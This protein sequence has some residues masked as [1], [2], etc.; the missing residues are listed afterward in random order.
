MN[1]QEIAL[2]ISKA[3]SVAPIVAIRQGDRNATTLK[4]AVFD[5]GAAF[6][7]SDY[8]VLL[9]AKLP[10]GA[11]Y[12]SAEGTT[13]GNVATF[14]VD[15]TY[16]AA[17]V[18]IT[19]EAYVDVLYGST[20]ICS[21]QSFRIVVEPGAKEG[22]VPSEGHIA[23][24]DAAC[25][26][27]YE[28][29]EAAWEAV[30]EM[31][32]ASVEQTSTGARITVTDREGTTTADIYNGAKGADGAATWTA[33][34]PPTTP[35]Y[36]FSK[37][38]LV[39]Q[40]GRTPKIGDLIIYSYNIYMISSTTTTTVRG[41]YPQ[42]IR[43]PKGD[44][45]QQGETGPKGDTGATGPQGIQGET[46]PQGEQGPQGETGPK[47]DTGATGP[48]GPKGDTGD[49]GPQG[50]KGDTGDAGPQGPKG[51]TGSQGPKGD[52][53]ETGATGPQGPKGDTGD[54]GATGPQGEQGPQGETGAQGA[55]GPQGPQG[56]TG[57]QGPQGET[58]DDGITPTVD[59]TTIAGGHNVAFVYG[60][61][62][63]RNVDFDVMDGAGAVSGVKGAA[64]SAYRTGDVSLSPEDIGA[65]GETHAHTSLG[66]A[67]TVEIKATAAGMTIDGTPIF[68]L[69]YPV[70]SIY[71][72]VNA[73]SPAT[74][75]GGTW[76]RITGRFLL[77]ATDNGSSGASQAAG[78]TGGA[79]T[80]TL[81]AA[82]S[83][84]PA[85]SHGMNS[86][87]H[88]MNHKHV[89]TSHS[90]GLNDHTHTLASHTHGEKANSSSWLK[91]EG[92]TD[93]SSGSGVWAGFTA[94]SS[95][96]AAQTG[97]PS[98]NTSGK[99]SGNTKAY[100]GYTGNSITTGSSASAG[101]TSR[102][103][104]DAATGSTASNTAADA[105]SSH[106]NMPPYLSVYVW[107]RTA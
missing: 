46:G 2:D 36:T 33:T 74:L 10:D 81:T 64:E 61:G 100:G 71:M 87:T 13:A 38:S 93:W 76:A 73:A 7:L 35:Y 101:N 54:T 80:V 92:R 96:G 3:A 49:T 44:T 82:Q 43:G 20:V 21:T 62:D 4:V 84:V 55:T 78:N 72:S 65:A 52:T 53:G 18:G 9:C 58:G 29:A 85:H 103:S 41:T 98:T 30:A 8:D 107:K 24:I 86:H 12:Y 75:F 89:L 79:A 69:I 37:A 32:T 102:A 48:Q 83:G 17:Y 47:G 31:P 25:A 1:T 56:A 70:G 94:A 28:A 23:E 14:L 106:N 104:T 40:M 99:A 39:G 45:G 5:N 51:D 97:G 26:E 68:D 60:S 59:V 105:S 90:H 95:S 22:V 6:D 91:F 67:S 77:A 42:S 50:P 15:E 11:H 27:A 66:D 16:A 88:G 57:P 63:P 19:D 34:D